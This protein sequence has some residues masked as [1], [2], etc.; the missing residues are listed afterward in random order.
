MKYIKIDGKKMQ[1]VRFQIILLVGVQM[2]ASKFFAPI[3]GLVGAEMREDVAVFL[4]GLQLCN[5]FF[6]FWGSWVIVLMLARP[7]WE[8][9]KL[10]MNTSAFSTPEEFQ[11]AIKENDPNIEALITFTKTRF[12]VR[13][14]DIINQYSPFLE[15]IWLVWGF[16]LA[17]FGGRA[18]NF[19]APLVAAIFSA[20]MREAI[21]KV[22]KRV[23]TM[24]QARQNTIF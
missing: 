16:A 21:H 20:Y 5:T 6:C 22:L 14:A 15:T 3:G 23:V 13:A 19:V 11:T 7:L 24:P 4:E 17:V 8:F 2:L 12:T 1:C 10:G 9:I 18:A